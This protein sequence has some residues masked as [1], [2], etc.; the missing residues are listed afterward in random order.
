MVAGWWTGMWTMMGMWTTLWMGAYIG[1]KKRH[2]RSDMER[3]EEADASQ[4]ERY[5]V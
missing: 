5:K 2:G 3:R 4:K 1:A